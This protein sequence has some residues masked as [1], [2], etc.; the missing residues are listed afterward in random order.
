[1]VGRYGPAQISSLSPEL[2]TTV[3]TSLW[4]SEVVAFRRVAPTISLSIEVGILEAWRAGEGRAS[5]LYLLAKA[6][7][8]ATAAAVVECG[9]RGSKGPWPRWQD[10]VVL[11]QQCGCDLHS[12]GLPLRSAVL[13]GNADAVSWLLEC[14]AQPEKPMEAD[15]TPL[16]WAARAGEASIVQA[17][18]DKKALVNARGRYGYTALMTAAMHGRYSVVKL[19]IAARAEVN[20]NSDGETALDLAHRYPEIVAMLHNQLYKVLS[21]T[22]FRT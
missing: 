1:M 2:L 9:L 11:L 16:R 18:L 3:G 15:L 12:S 8:E 13:A 19:L 17:L 7:G 4:P 22:K 5:A 20:T 14:R 10:A 6:A 21:T